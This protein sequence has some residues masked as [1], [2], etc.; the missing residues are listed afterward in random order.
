MKTL[1]H[2]IQE[3]LVIKKKERVNYKYF[4]QTLEELQ[5]IIDKRLEQEGNEANL[6]DIDVSKIT[7]MSYLFAGLDFNG[8]VSRWDVSNVTNM[9]HMFY[10][11]KKFN[12]DLSNWD[13][14]KV[15]NMAHMFSWCENFNQDLSSWDVSNVTDMIDMFN[16]CKNFNQDLSEW[17]VSN[18]KDYDNILVI[19]Q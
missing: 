11:C 15:T 8:D 5:D 18:V 10:G 19:V 14:S 16:G 12:Q 3:K 13:V 4:P 7:D 6:N 9:T 17:D 1:S 2:C